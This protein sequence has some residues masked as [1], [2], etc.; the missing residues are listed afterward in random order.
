MKLYN[1]LLKKIARA[2]IPNLLK[3]YRT[4]I[5]GWAVFL[6]GAY[7]KIMTSGIPD[8]TC[9][10]IPALCGVTAFL[11][12]G[13]AKMVLGLIIQILRGDTDAALPDMYT[14]PPKDNQQQPY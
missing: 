11:H 12:T 14:D 1:W 4:I 6:D 8:D 5:L 3:G 13:G 2:V 10:F 7:D 9:T